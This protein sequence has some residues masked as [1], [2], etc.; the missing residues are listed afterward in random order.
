MARPTKPKVASTP[1]PLENKPKKQVA[2]LIPNESRKPIPLSPLKDI[3]SPSYSQLSLPSSV[4]VWTP[5]SSSLPPHAF[6]PVQPI[7]VARSPTINAPSIHDL[8]SSPLGVNL[9]IS[10]PPHPNVLHVHT[11]H[12]TQYATYPPV[13]SLKLVSAGLPW[14]TTVEPTTSS[15]QYVTVLDVLHALY[16]NLHKRVKQAEFDASERSYRDS[17]T[18]AWFAR[19]DRIQHDSDRIKEEQKGV[20]RV[21]F[22]LGRT[23]VKGLRF[24]NASAKGETSWVVDFGT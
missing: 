11:T 19:L 12:L 2:F 23:R 24:S 4:S 16:A 13:R 1:R 17:I 3:P 10:R 6:S 14:V 5:P 15:I 8:L 20:R 18:A 7:P 21:D 9:D 22:L